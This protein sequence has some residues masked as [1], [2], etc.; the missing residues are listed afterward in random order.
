MLC[1]A[2]SPDG[3]Y[4]SSG[5]MDGSIWLWDTKTGTAVGCCKGHKKWITSVA[6]EPAHAMLPCRR[7]VSGSKDN[8]IKVRCHLLQSLHVTGRCCNEGL[9][10]VMNL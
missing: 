2:W 5:G 9:F 8:S 1:V 7:L 3:I 6:W 4:L 10:S